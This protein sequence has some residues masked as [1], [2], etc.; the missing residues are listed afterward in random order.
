MCGIF[1][2]NSFKNYERIYIE[3][4]RRGIFSY[5]SLY[6]AKNKEIYVKKH[7]GTKSL[8]GDY[9][10]AEEF[11]WYLG[12][13]QAPTSNQRE[14]SPRTTHPFEDMYHIV[15][16]NGVLENHEQIEEDHLINH[17]NPVDSSVIPAL[18]GMLLDF[19][20]EINLPDPNDETTKTVDLMAIEK[21]CMMLKGTF[22]CWFYSKLTG[23]VYLARSGSTLFG[24]INS[25]EFSS[26][27]VRG[28][29]EDELKEGVVYCVT[30]EGLAECGV[31]ETN[32]PFFL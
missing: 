12:H 1:G 20:D 23:C 8:T 10:Y 18:A 26:V 6:V 21:T 2:S 5:G 4:K 9:A 19:D 14:F 15:A 13:T 25:G 16:H 11:Q 27:R 31:F 32:S 3:N 29:V 30:T 24:N 17:M 28:L 22:A 7:K